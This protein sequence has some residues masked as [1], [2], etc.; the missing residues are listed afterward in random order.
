MSTGPNVEE[1]DQTKKVIYAPDNGDCH[2]VGD[3]DGDGVANVIGDGLGNSH[4][5]GDGD[6]DG[7][8]LHSSQ[9]SAPSSTPGPVLDEIVQS[10][11]NNNKD[12]EFVLDVERQIC[13]FINQ[14]V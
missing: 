11:L 9:P 5:D 4:G 1:T 2:G 12:T 10:A 8:A 3:G 13:A 7:G 6:G 14:Q